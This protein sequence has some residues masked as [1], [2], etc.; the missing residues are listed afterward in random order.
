MEYR[1]VIP[2]KTGIQAPAENGCA[3]IVFCD[4]LRFDASRKLGSHRGDAVFGVPSKERYQ[5]CPMSG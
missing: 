3:G 2:V 4:G 5:S 1:P